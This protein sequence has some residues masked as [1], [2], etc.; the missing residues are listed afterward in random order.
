MNLMKQLSSKPL[1]L[2]Y[3]HSLILKR[4][5]ISTQQSSCQHASNHIIKN[6]TVMGS[7]EKVPYSALHGLRSECNTLYPNALQ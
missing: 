6:N 2:S 3:A 4:S 7:S 5:Y 1:L